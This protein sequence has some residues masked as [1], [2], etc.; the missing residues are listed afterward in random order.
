MSG[1]R[2]MND[3]LGSGGSDDLLFSRPRKLTQNGLSDGSGRLDSEGVHK[4]VRSG[5]HGG[6]LNPEGG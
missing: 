4:H 2:A 1:I 6:V 3:K 5:R